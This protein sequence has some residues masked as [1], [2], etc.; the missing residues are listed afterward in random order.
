MNVNISNSSNSSNSSYEMIKSV[1]NCSNC[2]T[3]MKVLYSYTDYNFKLC[4]LCN[5]V[6]KYDAFSIHKGILCHTMLTQDQIIEL[7]HKFLKSNKRIPRINEIDPGAKIVDR[8]FVDVLDLIRSNDFMEIKL[9][10]SDMINYDHFSFVSM[11]AR[12]SK[13]EPYAFFNIVYKETPK[14]ELHA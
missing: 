13:Y 12:A 7:T 5:I 8:N 2:S 10:F 3:K 6:F 14:Y 9:F 4:E 1:A 11:F